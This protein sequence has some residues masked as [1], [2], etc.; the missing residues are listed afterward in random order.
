MYCF[1]VILPVVAFVLVF[2][3]ARAQQEPTFNAQSNLVLVPALVRD[4]NGD[5]V[6]GLK[7]KDFVIEDDGVEQAPHLDESAETES[8]S[9]TLGSNV[10]AGRSVNSVAWLAW[11]PCWSRS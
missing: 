6:Y 7:A 2:G 4:V 11:H 5:A 1:K 3:P 10:V 8:V 9:L